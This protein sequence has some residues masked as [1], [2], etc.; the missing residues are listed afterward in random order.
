MAASAPDPLVGIGSGQIPL[1]RV[2]F[3][4]VMAA[5]EIERADQTALTAAI[6][7]APF[8]P[9]LAITEELQQQVQDFDGF[10]RS[11]MMTAPDQGEMPNLPPTEARPPSARHANRPANQSG[12]PLV[13]P[14]SRPPAGCRTRANKLRKTPMFSQPQR[15]AAGDR[16]TAGS[17]GSRSASTSPREGGWLQ[18]ARTPLPCHSPTSRAAGRSFISAIR[19]ATRYDLNSMAAGPRRFQRETTCFGFSSLSLGAPGESARTKRI[20]PGGRRV[21]GNSIARCRVPTP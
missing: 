13:P 3:D 1:G 9:T 21:V 2:A 7:K 8:Y 15:G 4:R 17:S 14:A 19:G 20:P 6:A 11:F 16:P 18:P 10:S 12:D 5:D